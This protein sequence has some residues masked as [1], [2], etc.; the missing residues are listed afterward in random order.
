MP[1]MVAA[2]MVRKRLVPNWGVW[3][4][5]LTAVA[6]YVAVVGV[7]Q[8][9]LPAVNE[10]PDDFPA[11]VLWQFRIASLGM[12]VVMWTTIGLA[13]GALTERSLANKHR[14]PGLGGLRTLV[15]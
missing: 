10:V 13:F 1:S 15:R 8:A 12:Q 4:A 5:S 2:V 9:L 7:A 14:L 3:N 11:V 6:F